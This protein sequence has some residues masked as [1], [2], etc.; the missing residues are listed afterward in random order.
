MSCVGSVARLLRPKSIAIVGASPRKS[1]FGEQLSHATKSFG[2]SGRVSLVNP[3]YKEI[4]GAAC[5]SDLSE[6]PETPDC[7]L[8][9]VSDRYV[10]KA[11]EEAA[12]L[13]IGGAVVFG[14]LHGNSESGAA[15]TDEVAAIGRSTGMAVCGG[16]CMGFI[17]LIDGFQATGMPFRSLSLPSGVSLISHS[18]ST[19]SGLVGNQR[20]IGFDFAI[21]AGQELVTN[22]ADY[23]SFLV[24]KTDTRVIACVIETLRDPTRFLEAV[25]RAHAKGV[26]VVVLKLG[27][28]EAGRQFAISHSGAI[29]GS[30]SAYSAVF[31]KYRIISVRSLD[32]LLDT[33]EL[34][35]CSRQLKIPG[36]AVGTDSGGERQL[37]V[38]LAGDVGLGFCDLQP[39]TLERINGHLDPGITASNPLDYWGDGDDVMAPCLS[40][41]AEDPNVG[42]VVMATNLPPGRN[43]VDMC[44]R[45]VTAVHAKTQKPVALMGNMASTMSHDAVSLLRD[46]K[47]PVLMGTE[48][49]LRAIKNVV[50]Y[51]TRRGFLARKPMVARPPVSPVV[52]DAGADEGVG[53]VM[54]SAAGFRLLEAYNIG[55]ASWRD[56][57]SSED[58][59]RFG[60]E[61]GFPIV[62]KLDDPLIPHKSDVGGVIINVADGEAARS[63]FQKLRGAFPK[64][65]IIG[66]RQLEGIELIVGMTSDPNLGPMVTV[67]LG[68]IFVEIFNDVV[69]MVPPFDEA[70]ALSALQ[71]LRSHPI[72]AG[73]RGGRS[74]DIKILC[75]TLASFSLLCAQEAAKFS[76]LEINPLLVGPDGAFAVDCLAVRNL[77][78]KKHER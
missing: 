65:P 64:A 52:L 4:D 20:K 50:E 77:P 62:V 42:M 49:G 69:T 25:E 24:D 41:M 26:A 44:V 37:I 11:L 51:S 6:L 39:S 3:K 66:Q 5:Y 60:R 72:L 7:V 74:V 31:E 34:L 22:V 75:R 61:V 63:A 58:V 33:V 16:N 17:N 8:L 67:G 35:S 36:I 46:R 57:S 1:S 71:R 23:V 9:G 12:D 43:F 38:D 19:W 59:A 78:E 13:S 53:R 40:A 27:R 68:G 56:L 47:I 15:L 10:V 54:R 30:N 28:S 76:E 70:D 55:T 73:A 2:F 21:S 32:E 48:S 18:G 45:A 14:R 29:S